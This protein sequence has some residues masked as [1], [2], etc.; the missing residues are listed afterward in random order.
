[1][2]AGFSSGVKL[3]DDLE[4]IGVLG[5]ILDAGVDGGDQDHALAHIVQPL[6]DAEQDQADAHRCV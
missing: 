4:H 3:F 5:E 2:V 1:M 6:G